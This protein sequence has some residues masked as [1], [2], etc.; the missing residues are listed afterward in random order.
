MEFAFASIP[1][2]LLSL[3]VLQ[4][5]LCMWYYHTIEMAAAEGARYAS[6]KG[7]GCHYTKNSC[8]VTV[9]AVAAKVASASVGLQPALLNVTLTS[10]AGA[11]TCTPV[12][13]CYSN[14]APWPPASAT[15]N[16]V[17]GVTTFYSTP[18]VLAP[19][20]AN[21]IIHSVT[22]SANSQQKLVF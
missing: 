13:A 7:P 3:S 9:A 2:I 6:T 5:C 14:S 8:A 17:I 12:T 22:L 18:V 15:N 11:I 4:V 20:S 16:S 1:V 21:W 19:F 10:T